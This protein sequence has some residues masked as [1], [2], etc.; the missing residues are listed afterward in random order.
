MNVPN[1]WNMVEA[2]VWLLRLG[3]KGHVSCPW[4]LGWLTLKSQEPCCEN[5][6]LCG[7]AHEEL[8]L[9]TNS[10]YHFVRHASEPP[11]KQIFQLQ[12]SFQMITA[13]V[14]IRLQPHETP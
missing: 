7:G 3:H 10:L 6:Q 5:T 14:D 9:P 12:S 2:V 4:F 1:Y 8:K 11:W 13:S